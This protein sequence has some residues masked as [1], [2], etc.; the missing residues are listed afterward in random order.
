MLSDDRTVPAASKD[1]PYRYLGIEQVI[2]PALKTVKKKLVEKY[3]S[4]LRRIWSSNLNC[5]YNAQATN[6]WAV[7][8]FRYFFGILKWTKAD[9]VVLDTTTRRIMRKNRC[10]QYSVTPERLYLPRSR[11]GRGLHQLAHLRERDVVSTVSYLVTSA[12]PLLR[13]AVKHQVSLDKRGVYCV[14]GI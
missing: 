2:E 14:E 11:G 4:R 12:D 3:V 9:L 7:S 5:K 1:D 13:A 8:I 10:H 6:V